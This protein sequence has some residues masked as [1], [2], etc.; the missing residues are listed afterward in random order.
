MSFVDGMWVGRNL[1]WW[2]I[3]IL[4][5]FNASV[6]CLVLKIQ[7]LGG[8]VKDTCMRMYM[9]GDAS[10]VKGFGFYHLFRCF[11]GCFSLLGF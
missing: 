9:Y 11:L 7:I 4:W 5:G 1:G 2:V 6:A 3:L 8:M 10:S